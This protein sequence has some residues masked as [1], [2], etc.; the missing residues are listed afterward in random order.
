MGLSLLIPTYNE[1]ENLVNLINLLKSEFIKNKIKGEILIIDDNSPD[2]T[3]KIADQEAKKSYLVKVIH[4]RKKEGLSAAVLAG[5]EASK[6]DIVGVMDADL[7]HPPKMIGTMFKLI[8]EEKADLVIGSRYIKDGK[9]EG[10]NTWR[11]IQSKVATLLS[12]PFTNV[13]DTM[14]G[15]FLIRKNCLKNKDLN[16]KG[17]KILLEIIIKSDCE[18]IIE[19]PFTFVDRQKGK[20]KANIKEIFSLLNNLLSYTVYKIRSF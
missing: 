1:K 8:R 19:V 6:E 13:K 7:S 10:W 15:L 20:S 17:F 3:G 2:G 14:T 11:M 4:R 12:R 16:P 18:K 5:F 9:I